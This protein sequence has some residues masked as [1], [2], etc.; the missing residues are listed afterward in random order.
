MRKSKL[1]IL[2]LTVLP[3]LAVAQEITTQYY[4]YQMN[5]EP[6]FPY[7]DASTLSIGIY[8]SANMLRDE[9]IIRD[10]NWADSVFQ[11]SEAGFYIHEEKEN[12]KLKQFA[13]DIRFDC[14]LGKI[15]TVHLILYEYEKDNADLMQLIVS[16]DSLADMDEGLCYKIVY[17]MP[18]RLVVYDE[19]GILKYT[20]DLFEH[21]IDSLYFGLGSGYRTIQVID[22]ALKHH[23]LLPEM[24]TKRLI[25]LADPIHKALYYNVSSYK[26]IAAK[27]EPK[28]KEF[29]SLNHAAKVFGN[30]LRRSENRGVNR[31]SVKKLHKCISIWESELPN[32]DTNGINAQLN[33]QL[34]WH[35]YAGM[36][37]A[38]LILKAHEDAI[39]NV[40]KAMNYAEFAN[41]EIAL[42]YLKKF[43][44]DI[45][46]QE[47]ASYASNP[48]FPVPASEIESPVKPIFQPKI[49]HSIRFLDYAVT[50]YPDASRVHKVFLNRD[51]NK[52]LNIFDVLYLKE[53]H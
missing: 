39:S 18:G 36:A 44:T 47:T 43:H 25:N 20:E 40:L 22:T 12:Y 52:V 41:N 29:S 35:I 15:D 26:F 32:L 11:S 7:M 9:D 34:S 24:L 50:R 3:F 28:K 17:R 13:A 45:V 8:H 16:S 2:W 31:R 19:K 33:A 14:F 4:P 10:K 49:S 23:N 21:E 37:G 5:S 38:Q 51:R 1:L 48:H 42:H 53:Y 6:V 30:T 46:R 27:V